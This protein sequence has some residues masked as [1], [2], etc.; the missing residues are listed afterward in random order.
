MLETLETLKSW[1]QWGSLTLLGGFC[2]AVSAVI[3]WK[4][5]ER[6]GRILLQLRWA[7]RVVAVAFVVVCVMRGATKETNSPP[8]AQFSGSDNETT[9][10]HITCR[11]AID[12]ERRSCF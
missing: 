9:W 12:P 7:S 10:A 5:L 8:T 4:L 11:P 2:L 6:H 1:A 3:G